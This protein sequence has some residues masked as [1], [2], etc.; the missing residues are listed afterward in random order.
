MTKKNV[1][2]FFLIS[3]TTISCVFTRKDGSE[4][5]DNFQQG[6]LIGYEDFRLV[7]SLVKEDEIDKEPEEKRSL[8]NECFDWTF[9]ESSAFNILTKMKQVDASY[10]YHVC[11]YFPCWYKGTVSNGISGYEITI[12]AHGAITIEKDEKTIFFIMEDDSDLF[13]VPCGYDEN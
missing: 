4:S 11:Q 8:Y 9:K 5:N 6:V 13:I 12:Y 2:L 7:G 3:I 1:F 10:A